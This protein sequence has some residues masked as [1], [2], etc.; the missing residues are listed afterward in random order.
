[1]CSPSPHAVSALCSA[2][3]SATVFWVPHLGTH[4]DQAGAKYRLAAHALGP[5]G[6]RNT[7]SDPRCTLATLFTRRAPVLNSY[8]SI[9]TISRPFNS[10]FR[11]LFTFP[12]QYLFAIGLGSI[13]SLGRNLP[14]IFTQDS[15]PEL[16]EDCVRSRATVAQCPYGAIALLGAAF[17]NG[18]GT[19]D[20]H[21]THAA[22]RPQF[23]RLSAADFRPGLWPLHSP[24]LGPSLLLS[25][26]ALNDM[27][28]FRA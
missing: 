12:S 1:M 2:Y 11:V 5:S 26:P 18:L 6:S 10:L 27:L 25:F 7:S 22:H 3:Q 14:P 28:K 13:F 24:L 17:P 8:P 9:L 21:G 15:Q 4:A 19:P 16:L 23:D 20:N